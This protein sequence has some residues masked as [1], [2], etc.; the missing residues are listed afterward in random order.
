MSSKKNKKQKWISIETEVISIASGTCWADEAEKEHNGKHGFAG[1]GFEPKPLNLP[2]APRA[3]CESIIDESTVP[4]EGPFLVHMSNLQFEIDEDDITNY[5]KGLKINNIKLP[6]ND[7]G[8]NKGFGYV[9]F[10]ERKELITALGME[11]LIRGRRVRVELASGMQDSRNAF[12]RGSRMGMDFPSDEPGDWRSTN[13]TSSTDDRGGFTRRREGG[14]FDKDHDSERDNGPW[15]SARRNVDED[16]GRKPFSD[17]RF[18]D[19][20]RRPFSDRRSDDPES[21]RRPFGDRRGDDSEGGRRPFGDRR[22]DDFDGGRRPFGDRRYDDSEGGRRPFGER[23]DDIEG[24]R[25]PFGESRRGFGFKRDDDLPDIAGENTSLPQERPKLILKPKTVDPNA[26]KTE[27]PSYVAAPSIFGAAKPVDTAAK[28][29][30]IEEKL[31]AKN[32]PKPQIELSGASSETSLNEIS[33]NK[34]QE[35]TEVKPPPQP[36]S[37]ET[38]RRRSPRRTND[39]DRIP[40]RR[41]SPERNPRYEEAPPPRENA[42]EK[43]SLIKESLSSEEN[44][45]NGTSTIVED[46]KPRPN[47]YIPPNLRKKTQEE[48]VILDTVESECVREE[49]FSDLDKNV[50]DRAADGSELIETIVVEAPSDV[51]TD[52]DGQSSEPD[53]VKDQSVNEEDTNDSGFIECGKNSSDKY[54]SK[55]KPKVIKKLSETEVKKKDPVITKELKK[56]T[57]NKFAALLDDGSNE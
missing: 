4:Q 53:V 25:K 21:G 49:T 56:S 19:S 26:P 44:V 33:D 54:K 43:H 13:R 7:N 51:R 2:K 16:V 36:K 57:S 20:E 23:R 37:V 41:A 55:K 47:I 38:W 22:G 5:F 11:N 48:T 10:E 29:R 46:E 52:P 14:A 9:E 17:R 12:Q 45:C 30:E 24:G 27:A 42:W 28:E 15:R 50:P 40:R 6:R 39:D 18:D 32:E 3:A 34:C 35:E 8:R 1:F 31:L